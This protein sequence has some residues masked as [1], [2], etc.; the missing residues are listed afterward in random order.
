VRDN[1]HEFTIHVNFIV[2]CVYYIGLKSNS[3]FVTSATL[4]GGH[5]MTYII[6][7]VAHSRSNL[8]VPLVLWTVAY[9][10]WGIQ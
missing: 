6:S 1:V 5:Y 9:N 2:K 7:S 4:M 10:D 8:V 3:C